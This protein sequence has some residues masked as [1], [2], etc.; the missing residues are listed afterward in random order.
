MPTQNRTLHHGG[1]SVTLASWEDQVPPNHGF[2]LINKPWDD[3]KP[4]KGMYFYESTVNYMRNEGA[5][6]RMGAV[7][8]DLEVPVRVDVG[9]GQQ[10]DSTERKQFTLFYSEATD[11]WHSVDALDID[12]AREWKQHL[13]DKHVDNYADAHMA[14]NDVDNLRMLPAVHNRARDKIDGIIGDHGLDSKQFKAWRREA[15]EFDPDA[16]HPAFDP[17]R[18]GVVRRA[19][20]HDTEWSVDDGREGLSFDARV[21]RIWVDN[22]LSK[23]YATTV[24]I[25]DEDSGKEYRVPLFRCPKTGQLVTRDAF[26]I[27]HAHPFSD[28][29]R[30]LCSDA[31]NGKISKAEALDAYNDVSNLRLVNRAANASHEWELDHDGRYDGKYDFGVDDTRGMFDGSP[32]PLR[33]N[34]P[35]HP[36]FA[37]YKQAIAGLLVA[38]PPEFSGMNHL[39]Y[40]NAASSL[41]R[42]AVG[43]GLARIDDVR[44]NVGDQNLVAVEGNPPWNGRYAAVAMSDAT[45]R[46]LEQNS[47]VMA[48]MPKP[49]GTMLFTEMHGLRQNQRFVLTQ[50]FD[51]A[52]KGILDF[53]YRRID[54]SKPPLM[55]NPS[56]PD[57]ADFL[58]AQAEIQ[59]L[60]PEGRTLPHD[61]YRDN[62]AA[63]VVKDARDKGI[64]HIDGF[65]TNPPQKTTLFA[66]QGNAHNLHDP[67]NLVSATNVSRGALTPIDWSTAK[68]DELHQQQALAAQRQNQNLSQNP[69]NQNPSPQAQPIRMN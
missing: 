15:L 64:A 57:H 2:D 52:D 30:E 19:S 63:A 33:M 40:E 13:V 24:S 48:V 38:A 37:M 26:D 31:P 32:Q 66:I 50:A 49:H 28:V 67:G 55:S 62:L 43:E 68:V 5:R 29:L 25:H 56:H 7:D 61:S 10:V 36:H 46:T 69:Q 53:E 34:E 17:G 42:A 1:E 9:F 11:S 47:D 20:T 3:D 44:L 41:V 54:G 45:G 6:E 60:D 8:F 21:K 23:L 58:K 51:L 59:R 14:Y 35:D 22:E 16:P 39:E 12:H 27:D 4:R 65:A 18:D